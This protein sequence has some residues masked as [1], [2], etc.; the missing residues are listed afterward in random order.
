MGA[1]HDVVSTKPFSRRQ[2]D[3]IL[4]LSETFEDIARG[5]R[6]SQLLA[7]K[8]LA[9]L[10]Y[11]P[12][13]RT[14]LSF[15]SA[16]VRLG[17]QLLSVA[18]ALKTSSA[19]K[20]ESLEDT[21]LT[22]E[23]YADVIALRHPERGAGERAAAAA[24]VPVISGGDDANEHPTQA[25][26][27]L[28]TIRREQG[29]IDGLT[30]MLVGDHKH[31]RVTNSLL[32]AL[33][34]YDVKVLLVNPPELATAPDVL[35]YVRNKGLETEE[36]SDLTA[37]LKKTDVVYIFRIQKERFADPQEYERV[38]GSYVINRAMLDALGKVITVMHPMPRLDELSVEV[39]TY[40][41]ACYFRQSFNGVLVRMALLAL[42]LG[43]ADLD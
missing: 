4:N 23:N 21:I 18:D 8:V 31:S 33:A 2:L 24:T 20:G 11:E 15:E 43:R 12:S 10:F 27:D 37:A 1:I 13:T 6:L 22:V 25:L 29:H 32:Y 7:G 35:T 36:T 42:V 19:W 14:R 34:N 28:L 39:D 16:M 3:G 17:G 38:K 40:P 41:G 26:L 9:T 5:N 30:V